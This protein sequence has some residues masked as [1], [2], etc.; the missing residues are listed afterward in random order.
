MIEQ[1]I[2]D[3]L[4]GTMPVQ[5]CMEKPP[6][7]PDGFVLL[8]KTSSWQGNQ[9]NGATIAIQSYG[10][11]LYEAAKL[12]ERVITAMEEAESMD[13]ISR[14]ELNSDYNFTDTETKH[15]RYQ[16]VYQITYYKEDQ[17]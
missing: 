8:E 15:Y 3:Y 5:V 1:I 6:N 17:P 11:S 7:P 2:L 12:N 4:N 16:A 13:E 9:L 14:V 10:K